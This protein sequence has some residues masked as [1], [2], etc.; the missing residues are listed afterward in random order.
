MA[1]TV[2]VWPKLDEGVRRD[3]DAVQARGCHVVLNSY[4]KSLMAQQIVQGLSFPSIGNGMPHCIYRLLRLARRWCE[5]A[6]RLED[7]R[8]ASLLKQT[9]KRNSSP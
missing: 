6:T 4:L 7:R 9:T 5:A 8:S 3:D 1:S 2:S